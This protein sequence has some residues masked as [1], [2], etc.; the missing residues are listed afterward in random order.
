VDRLVGASDFD[1]R[2][3]EIH[4]RVGEVRIELQ[5]LGVPFDR[6]GIR[7]RKVQNA[8]GCRIDDQRQGVKRQCTLN[9]RERLDGAAHHRE[10][11]GEEMM[12]GR[13]ARI[14]LESP[15]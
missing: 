12:R 9:G 6:L 7:S 5:R 15:G 2:L 1:I 8:P 4:V 3:S 14:E 11:H 10:V 13:R